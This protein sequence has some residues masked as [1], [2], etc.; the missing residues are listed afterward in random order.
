LETKGEI[1]NISCV[2]TAVVSVGGLG[3]L[4]VGQISYVSQVRNVASGSESFSAS[5]FAPFNMDAFNRIQTG[6][7]SF[8][9]LGNAH[10]AS[11][12]NAGSIG[13]NLTSF[14]GTST[15]TVVFDAAAG[16]ILTLSGTAH[17]SGGPG[18]F[19]GGSGIVTITGPDVSYSSPGVTLQTL[20]VPLDLGFTQ[21]LAGG[22]YT[23]TV[24]ANSSGGYFQGQYRQGSGSAIGEMTLTPTPGAAAALAIG[25]L[26]ALRRRRR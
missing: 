19:A 1:M 16:S 17:H 12:L 7:N 21:I 26:T 5:D 4:A 20:F 23:L 13:F 2:L 8:Q 15:L 24:A 11:T 9:T 6:P 22:T 25:G 18:T 14:W 10:H 3:G